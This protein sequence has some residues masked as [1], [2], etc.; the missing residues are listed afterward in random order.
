M[1]LFVKCCT[2]FD[3][4]SDQGYEHLIEN[5]FSNINDIYECAL[6]LSDLLEETFSSVTSSNEQQPQQQILVGQYFWELAEG[7]EFA[8]YLKY[9]LS[10]TSYSQVTNSIKLIINNPQT[11]KFLRDTNSG[12]PEISKYLLPKLLLGSIY[13]ILYIYETVEYLL[14]ISVDD[15]DKCLLNDTLDTLKTIK[16]KLSEINFSHSRHR[17]I[18]TSFRVFQP[19]QLQQPTQEVMPPSLSAS[20][21][22]SQT[23]SM[24][25]G[26]ISLL[27]QT[28]ITCER[29]LVFNIC[30]LTKMKWH[31]I[32]NSVE[33]F[34][35]PT[36]VTQ[37]VTQI[38][39]LNNSSSSAISN[40]GCLYSS[41]K[42]L[43]FTI[44]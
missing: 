17:P 12:L 7:D 11:S 28:S 42:I 33:S 6:R 24:N 18:E 27:S 34:K 20:Q 15:E 25:S 5:I 32:E 3:I 8:V 23:K 2:Q 36:N 44:F 21:N 19:H 4:N 29:A 10:V 1:Y 30:L 16:Y 35:L 43:I 39:A 22:I 40:S 9:A 26:S 41:K 38:N 31:E 14:Q 37:P 13:H